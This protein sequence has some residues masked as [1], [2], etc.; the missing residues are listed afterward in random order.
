MFF[1]VN[2]FCSVLFLP[3]FE[4]L[5]NIVRRCVEGKSIANLMLVD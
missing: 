3:M 1:L 2:I 4:S 5:V